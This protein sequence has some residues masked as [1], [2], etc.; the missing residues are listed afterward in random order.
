MF[1]TRRRCWIEFVISAPQALCIY[2]SSQ[3]PSLSPMLCF[4]HVYNAFFWPKRFFLLWFPKGLEVVSVDYHVC[5]DSS[6]ILHWLRTNIPDGLAKTFEFNKVQQPYCVALGPANT[7]LM[8][9]M[10]TDGQNWKC[11]ILINNSH[12]NIY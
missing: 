12:T 9:C 10:G 4:K 3:L 6:L 5:I 8:T 11:T 7:Y 2:N 1:P